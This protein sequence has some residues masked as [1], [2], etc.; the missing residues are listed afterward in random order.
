MNW[1]DDE[2]N[3]SES[4]SGPPGYSISIR[5]HGIALV[6]PTGETAWNLK[7]QNLEPP[8]F[9]VEVDQCTFFLHIKAL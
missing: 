8:V 9:S 4:D 7:R 1:I 3:Y 5:I 6:P 2:Q